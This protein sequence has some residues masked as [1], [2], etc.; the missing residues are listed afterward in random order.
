MSF[1]EKM[2]TLPWYKKLTALRLLKDLTQ[3]A[4]AGELGIHL[5]T[6]RRWE[7][8]KHYPGRLARRTLARYHQVTEIE[9]FG[10]ANPNRKTRKDVLAWLKL[11]KE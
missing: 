4:I 2:L 7:S 10:G 5:D 8:G 6:Y 1:T 11:L 9:V 3:E